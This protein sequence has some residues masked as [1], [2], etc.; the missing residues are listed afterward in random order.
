MLLKDYIT[1]NKNFNRNIF[2]SGIAFNSS[3]VKKNNIFFAFKGNKYDGNNYIAEA[4]KK[5]AKVIVSENK[6]VRNKKENVLFLRSP[7]VRKLLSKVSYKIFS[8]KPKTLV[9][10][11]GT[12]GKSSIADFYYQ[13]L[14]LNSK[15]VAS[16]GT[17]G[18]KHKNKK[19]HSNLKN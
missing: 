13:I 7:N 5:G 11:T 15:K 1:L 6:I 19:I 10:V 12:N 9:G 3:K 18:I 16:I 17:I 14:D 8:Q 2:F 4:I